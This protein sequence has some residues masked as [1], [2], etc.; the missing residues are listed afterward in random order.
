MSQVSS[1]W[2]W[3][4]LYRLKQIEDPLSPRFLRVITRS[5]RKIFCCCD[6][7]RLAGRQSWLPKRSLIDRKDLS[8]MCAGNF[9]SDSSE[10]LASH[11]RQ[12]IR[13]GSLYT[14]DMVTFTFN[15][16]SISMHCYCISLDHES[17]FPYIEDATSLNYGNHDVETVSPDEDVFY[18]SPFSTLEWYRGERSSLSSIAIVMTVSFAYFREYI[19]CLWNA[20]QFLHPSCR[21]HQIR[22]IP[23]PLN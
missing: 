1:H 20:T 21:L 5:D 9:P 18:T 6:T 2:L 10:L 8:P 19:P 14:Y 22:H 13:L 7:S 23:C 4:L 16:T 15:A 3:V 17:Y 12:A 11:I